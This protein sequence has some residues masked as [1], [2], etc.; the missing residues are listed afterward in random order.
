MAQQDTR[1][2]QRLANYSLALDGL[3]GE[4]DLA[5]Q[6]ELSDLEKKG[7]IQ[8][9]EYVH[10]LAWVVLKDFFEFTGET[11]IMGSRDAFE[12]AFQRN[13]ITQAQ[14]LLQGIKDRNLTVHTYNQK[15]ANRIF[16]NILNTYYGAFEEVR[17]AILEEKKKRGL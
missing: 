10:E 3:K 16:Q 6:R 14:A 13:L 9:F 11:N 17:T 7:V 1:F 15:I 4:I 2:V 5:S 12:L 8:S